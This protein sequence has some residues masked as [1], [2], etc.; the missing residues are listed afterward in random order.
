MITDGHDP[1]ECPAVFV[2][3]CGFCAARCSHDH[4]EECET[5]QEGR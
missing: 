1:Y 4:T 5:L 2:A 3:G